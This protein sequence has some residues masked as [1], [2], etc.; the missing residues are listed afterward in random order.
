LVVL[1]LLSGTWLNMWESAVRVRLVNDDIDKIDLWVVF[2]L[3]TRLT[4]G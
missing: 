2:E 4:K 3:G 1:L